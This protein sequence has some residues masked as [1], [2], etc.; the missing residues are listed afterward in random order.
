MPDAAGGN[1][2]VSALD[3]YSTSNCV[4]L[5][6]LNDDVFI[7]TDAG[8]RWSVAHSM[9]S[10]GQQSGLT[11]T[12]N[13]TC[14]LLSNL[15]TGAA[16]SIRYDGVAIAKSV[17]GGKGWKEVYVSKV[18]PES[19][20]YPTYT[21]SSISCPT[22]LHCF[23]V[24][25]TSTTSFFLA[26]TNGGNSWSRLSASEP[27]GALA[28]PSTSVCYAV[29]GLQ[30]SFV[31]KST[32]GARTWSAMPGP[33]NFRSNSNYAPVKSY[34]L[35]TITCQSVTWCAA[36]GLETYTTNN[37]ASYPVVWG[38]A[39]GS[40]WLFGGGISSS[41]DPA[42]YKSYV[43]SDGLS[44]PSKNNCF[45]AT[46]YG[47]IID[48]TFINHKLEVSQDAS[49]PTSYAN[50]VALSCPTTTLCVDADNTKSLVP[51]FGVLPV[52]AVVP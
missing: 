16:A 17:N 33:S 4:A 26:T 13:G 5:S 25:G 20:Q 40:S 7:S 12:T 9:K 2:S 39:N 15:W 3:C 19:G 47:S 34:S 8:H 30:N 41:S 27:F 31:Y 38:M 29:D 49:S 28:C 18:R 23:V 46:S 43:P 21:L 42:Y 24:G 6:A 14:F 51:R 32:N 48:V 44:C 50:I 10:L 45:A 35:F 1:Q 37:L 22:A 36:G 52:S 11:C